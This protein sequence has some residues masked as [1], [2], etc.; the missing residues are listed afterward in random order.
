MRFL[1]REIIWDGNKFKTINFN[2]NLE[3]LRTS[4][5]RK[6]QNTLPQISYSSR[7]IKKAIIVGK[8]ARI[9]R[10]TT[11]IEDVFWQG[12]IALVEL[13]ILGYNR[14]ILRDCCGWMDAQYRLNIWRL[15]FKCFYWREIIS[16][17]TLTFQV[18]GL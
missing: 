13:R 18:E 4:G 10:S 1:D 16:C 9:Q 15:L 3:S 8:F 12:L 6:F 17:P 2:K 14:N 11:E 5:T 7:T